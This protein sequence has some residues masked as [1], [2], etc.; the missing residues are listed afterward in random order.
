MIKKTNSIELRKHPLSSLSWAEF[1]PEELCAIRSQ[2]FC[3]PLIHH[4][5]VKGPRGLVGEVKND[6]VAITMHGVQYF[7][8]R[9]YDAVDNDDDD[10]DDDDDDNECEML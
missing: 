7:H 10:D 5:R 6:T 3:H 2:T 9:Q 1:A 8:D 4:H